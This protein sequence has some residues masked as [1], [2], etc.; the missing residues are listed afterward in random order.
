MPVLIV[1]VCMTGIGLI[2]GFGLMAAYALMLLLGGLLGLVAAGRLGLRLARK[3]A[4]PRTLTH[5]LALVVATLAVLLIVK[6]PV[7][8]GLV[9]LV[10]IVSGLGAVTGELW[11]RY[12]Q[13]A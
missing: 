8:G 5:A 10:L 9:A 13:T 11:G 3:D 2:V 12:R 1:L 7:L 6:I 4:A